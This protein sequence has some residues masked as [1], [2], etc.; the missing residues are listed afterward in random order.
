MQINVKFSFIKLPFS[1]HNKVMAVNPT[2]KEISAMTDVSIATVSRALSKPDKVKFAT[3]KKI[4][5]AIEEYQR[6]KKKESSNLVGFIVP[7]LENQFF[8]LM[9]SGADNAAAL[10]GANIITLCSGNDPKKEDNIIKKLIDMHVDGVIMST[11]GKA[12]PLL[13]Q[14][15]KDNIIPIIFLDRDPEIDNID[16]ITTDNYDGMYQSTKYLLTLGHRDILYLGGREGTSTNK[17]REEGFCKAIGEYNGISISMRY[18]EYDFMTS[19]NL[20][21]EMIKS[22]HLPFTAIASANDIMALG[23]IKAFEE[24]GIRIPED[25]SIIGYDDIPSA[26]Y[27]SL[28]T[29]KQPFREMGRMA[30]YQLSSIIQNQFRPKKKLILNSTIIFRSSCAVRK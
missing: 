6:E 23:A 17:A 15:I 27:S 22:G 3:R 26:E 13:H 18:G 10:S 30:F 12:S 14:I 29:V 9:L 25:I 5:A 19:Y 11:S 24:N 20:F 21:K 16:L 7:D 1:S 28:T 8:P 2:L 4:E